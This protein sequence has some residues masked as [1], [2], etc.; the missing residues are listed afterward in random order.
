MII[1]G[2]ADR[3]IPPGDILPG[4]YFNVNVN[5]NHQFIL[6]IT[7]KASNALKT[8]VCGKEESLQS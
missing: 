5:V 2:C 7:A 8:L 3:G 4:Y 1:A 6:R